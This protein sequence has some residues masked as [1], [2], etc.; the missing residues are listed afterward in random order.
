[1]D[2]WGQSTGVLLEGILTLA[3]YTMTAKVDK[4]NLWEAKQAWI[5]PT[6]LIAIAIVA[7]IVVAAAVI[8]VVRRRKK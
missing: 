2:Y 6:V 4:T 7:I 5:D 8:L 3:D 1:V